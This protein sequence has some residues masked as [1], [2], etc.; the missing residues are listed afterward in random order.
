MIQEEEPSSTILQ[1]LYK[2]ENGVEKLKKIEELPK[3]SIEEM[4]ANVA[5]EERIVKG[6]VIKY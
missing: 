2:L 1:E 6:P 4:L 5:K 3:Q